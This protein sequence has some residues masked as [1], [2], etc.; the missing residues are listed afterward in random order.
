MIA[1]DW[2]REVLSL[3][4]TELT[5]QDWFEQKDSTDETIRTR[6]GPLH[7]ALAHA[8]P[9]M[10]FDDPDTALAAI[11]V[12]DQFPRNMFRGQPRA[13]ATD[14]LALSIARQALERGFDDGVPEQRKHF[15]FMPFMHSEN[16]A[17]QERCV[18]LFAALPGDTV[19]YAIEHRDIV[20]RFGR[21]PHRNRV[22]GRDTTDAEQAFLT[23]HE[24]F[25]Q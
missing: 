24:G 9:S 7:R 4:F 21:F 25:G 1:T 20:A 8:A 16:A 5:P 14:G 22:L 10:L 23:D 17:D 11:I 13:F 2:P 12:L 18:A 3:W 15:F 6:F 19:K